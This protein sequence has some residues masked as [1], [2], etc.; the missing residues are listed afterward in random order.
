[1]PMISMSLEKVDKLKLEVED[2]KKEI[3]VLEG[4]DIKEI[5][6]GDLDHLLEVLD[7]VEEEELLEF[8]NMKKLKKN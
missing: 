7:E 4:T 1:M 3:E 8:E 5:W 2:K 6:L